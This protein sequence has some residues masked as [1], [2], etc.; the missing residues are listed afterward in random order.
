MIEACRCRF[1]GVLGLDNLDYAA[2][3]LDMARSH[4]QS[5][6]NTGARGSSTHGNLGRDRII[7]T[8]GG[9]GGKVGG[10]QRSTT[11]GGASQRRQGGMSMA[12]RL[13][14]PRR[15]GQPAFGR[16]GLSVSPQDLRKMMDIIN[17]GRRR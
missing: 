6:L 17:A 8:S 9:G 7:D 4:G 1:A 3:V 11:R 5:R 13:T 15:G 2:S 10:R 16:L 12:T 14:G